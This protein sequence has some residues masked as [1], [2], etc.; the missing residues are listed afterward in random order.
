[1]VRILQGIR[2]AFKQFLLDH[3]DNGQTILRTQRLNLIY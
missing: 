3:N 2:K 1:M